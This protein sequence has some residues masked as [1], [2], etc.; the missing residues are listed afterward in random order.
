[1]VESASP[2]K[3]PEMRLISLDDVGNCLPARLEELFAILEN[4]ARRELLVR[5]NA[6]IGIA[7]P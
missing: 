4:L 5:E 2:R 7:L 3:A 1:M 6:E